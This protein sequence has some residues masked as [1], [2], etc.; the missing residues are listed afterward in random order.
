MKTQ[1]EYDQHIPTFFKDQKHLYFY[2]WK[3]QLWERLTSGQLRHR[4]D[5]TYEEG[6]SKGYA[7]TE[8][9]SDELLKQIEKRYLA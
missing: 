1:M 5:L 2:I 9:V 3:D 7:D 8:R 4:L 6:I